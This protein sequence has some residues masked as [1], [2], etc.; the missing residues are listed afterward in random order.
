MTKPTLAIPILLLLS[1]LG[2]TQQHHRDPL[3]DQEIDK[4]RDA[5]Q[6]PDAR[7]KLYIEFARARLEKLQQVHSD[8]KATDREQQT[9]DA[10][11][12]SG[13][14]RPVLR[15]AS[16]KSSRSSARR[17]TSSGAP[18]SSAPNRRSASASV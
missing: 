7:L 12:D 14:A 16:R 2:F 3:N 15:T 1:A 6:E 8:A 13:T 11:R 4:V 9:R 5:A 18:I 17:M 10:I